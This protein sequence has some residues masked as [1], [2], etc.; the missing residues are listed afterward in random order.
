MD[1]VVLSYCY[2]VTESVGLR[3]DFATWAAAVLR[4]SI[5]TNPLSQTENS[6]QVQ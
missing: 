4:L 5:T 6:S 2:W 1:S 3:D